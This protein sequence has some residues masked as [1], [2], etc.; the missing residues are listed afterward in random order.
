VPQPGR[1]LKGWKKHVKNQC[2][3]EKVKILLGLATCL[4]LCGD[5]SDGKVWASSRAGFRTVGLIFARPEEAPKPP[6]VFGRTVGVQAFPP[7]SGVD[8]FQRGTMMTK[9]IDISAIPELNTSVGMHGSIK[10]KE[11][12]GPLCLGIVISIIIAI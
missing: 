8:K 7:L 4:P 5:Y 2:I 3:T 11:V 6:A 12:F 1:P 10:Q 9:K